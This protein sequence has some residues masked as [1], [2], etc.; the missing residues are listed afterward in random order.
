MQVLDPTAL[1]R[2]VRDFDLADLAGAYA[3]GTISPTEGA[4]DALDRIEHRGEDGTWITVAGRD[5]LLAQATGLKVRDPAERPLY[6][7]RSRSRTA[8][9][10]PVGRPRWPAR[11]TRTSRTTA[12][13]IGR[14]LDAGAIWSARPISTSSPPA[15]TAPAPRTASRAASS[16]AS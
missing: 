4:G 2:A 7:V 15:S 16:A 13:A 6:G 5:A 11:T 3:A 14:L 1:P 12:P 8:S 9:T 10:S